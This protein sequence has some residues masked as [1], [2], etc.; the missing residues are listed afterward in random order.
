MPARSWQIALVIIAVAHLIGQWLGDRGLADGTQVLL[1]PAV[2]G[3]VWSAAALPRRAPATSAYGA[4]LGFSWLGDWLP[5]F[6][7][8]QHF[9]VLVACFLLAQ[10]CFILTFSLSSRRAPS[11]W[12]VTGYAAVFAALFL[13]CRAGAGDLLPLVALYG[14]LLVTTGACATT[15]SPLVAG[16]AALFVLSDSLIALGHFLP[17]FDLPHH[18]V[19]VMATYIA[20]QVLIAYGLL[21]HRSRPP[22]GGTEASA[23]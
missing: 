3:T 20:A 16:G 2:A 10:I 18:Q 1:V 13:A 11:W 19:A 6:A 14:L 8:D 9:V 23:G 15:V 5:R 17:G 12:A 21:R 4:A 22:R 7:G